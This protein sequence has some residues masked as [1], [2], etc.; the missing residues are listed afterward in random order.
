[1]YDFAHGECDFVCVGA[2]VVRPSPP[3]SPMYGRFGIEQGRRPDGSVKVRAVDH[4]SWSAPPE[5]HSGYFAKYAQLK[6]S[7]NGCTHLPE[8]VQHDHID[9]LAMVMRRYRELFGG[10]PWL[11]KADVDSAFRRVPLRP[12]HRWAA[13]VVYSHKGKAMVAVHN[14]CPF[15]ASSAVFNWERV[16]VML[17]F[18]ARRVL[19]LALLRYVDDFFGPERGETVAHAMG[20]FARLVRLLL[21]SSAIAD[22][23]LEYGATLV[24]LGVEVSPLA[25]GFLMRPAKD[26]K[27]KC[28]RAIETALKC[29]VLRSGCAEKLAGRLSW[30]T[31]FMFHRL[32]RAMIRAIFDQCRVRSGCV[33]VLFTPW[34]LTG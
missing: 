34:V 21:G 5:G 7:V 23:K 8:E 1:M 31:Q 11:L 4:L 14:A 27:A 2:C 15:G 6:A 13:A 17:A 20:C 24:V 22:R 19:K 16:G 29:N 28:I 9:L 25:D 32:G 10:P 30:A 18:F 12:D 26:K 33:C 3:P